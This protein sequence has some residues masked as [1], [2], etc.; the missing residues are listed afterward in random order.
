MDT[1]SNVPILVNDTIEY[2]VKSDV[3]AF[4]SDMMEKQ[5]TSFTILISVMSAVFVAI[6]GATW[7][8]NYK[9]AKQQ[10]KEEIA[11]AKEDIQ[12]ECEK[13]NQE[14]LTTAREELQQSAE[15]QLQ[16]ALTKQ[17]ADYEQYKNQTN[18]EI[19][20]Q[21]AELARIFALFCY[22]TRDYIH[23]LQWWINALDSYAAIKNDYSVGMAIENIVILLKDLDHIDV[24]KAE[25][26]I[27][28]YEAV[29]RE[30]IPDFRYNDKQFILM[31]LN[32]IR[33]RRR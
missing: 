16:D 18:D 6:I 12:K 8:W 17:A 11:I 31:K 14:Q 15:R 24:T 13:S 7:W 1:I 32:G 3:V 5:A 28:E 29:V 25:M 30:S 4:Y 27:D 21:S 19:T 20:M 22:T 2:L 33:A 9:G 10:I 23:S 26:D